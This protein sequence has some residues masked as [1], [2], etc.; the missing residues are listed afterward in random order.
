MFQCNED[1]ES[2][3][4]LAIKTERDPAGAGD[5][6]PRLLGHHQFFPGPEMIKSL[7]PSA[8]KTGLLTG[9]AQGAG[10]CSGPL[11]SLAPSYPHFLGMA[12]QH[13]HLPENEKQ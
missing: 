3:P 11:A 5:N 7:G 1:S 4:S 13:Q 10:S 2:P 6:H 12:L 8:T 9:G